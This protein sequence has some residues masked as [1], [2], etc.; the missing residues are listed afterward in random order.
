MK[1][2]KILIDVGSSSI[3]VYRY[4]KK[5]LKLILTK[6]FNFKDGFTSQK[7]ITKENKKELFDLI[8]KQK[9]E[10]PASSISVY[11][12]AIFRKYNKFLKLNFKKEF[13]K[14]TKVNFNIISQK[15]ENEYLEA[16]L[17]SKYNSKQPVLLINIG[18]GSTEL[19]V[20]KNTKV[21]EKKNIAIGVGTIIERFEGINEKTSKVRLED[22]VKYVL[23]KLPSLKTKVKIAFYTGGE[24]NYMKLVK[25]KL[26]KNNLFKDKD[27]PY[28]ILFEDFAKR[29]KDIFEK[30]TLQNLEDSMSKNPKWMHGAR[31][32]S[33]FAQG[34]CQGNGIKIIIP[35]D[36]NLING[37]VRKDFLSQTVV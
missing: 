31:S 25:Y 13:F 18:G 9:R 28:I 30:I 1:S 36:S 4:S 24:L 5:N 7:G 12:T 37:I 10:N 15:A 23:H 11:A 6:S 22:V 27:H 34:I 33:A 29:N 26:T 17:I 35:S 16:S 32:C 21:I 19:V 14:N 3:K 20:V 8:N 2:S